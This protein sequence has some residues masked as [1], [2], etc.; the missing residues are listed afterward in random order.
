MAGAVKST[1]KEWR[2][3]GKFNETSAES[4]A[5]FWAEPPFN[6]L[7]NSQLALLDLYFPNGISC[8][9]YSTGFSNAAVYAQ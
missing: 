1:D 5:H 2:W 9:Y 6:Y 4:A 3:K 8:I 7:D